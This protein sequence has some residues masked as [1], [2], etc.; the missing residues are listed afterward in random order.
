MAI[1]TKNVVKEITKE[2]ISTKISNAYKNARKVYSTEKMGAKYKILYDLCE[3][4]TTAVR[5]HVKGIDRHDLNVDCRKQVNTGWKSMKLDG[6]GE[7]NSEKR[8]KVVYDC[9]EGKIY[10]KCTMQ[11]ILDVINTHAIK[12]FKD[13]KETNFRHIMNMIK[14]DKGRKN[15]DNKVIGHYVMIDNDGIVKE[16][17]KHEKYVGTTKMSDFNWK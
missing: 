7:K 13:I 3:F 4:Y 9:I 14:E 15:T 17:K 12:T 6:T 2:E 1:I 8:R 16:C 11:R 5:L 10:G